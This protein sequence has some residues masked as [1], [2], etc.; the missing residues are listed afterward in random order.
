MSNFLNRILDACDAFWY[1][2]TEDEG[3]RRGELF[4]RFVEGFFPHEYFMLIR[5]TPP[6]DPKDRFSESSLEP[7]FLFEDRGTRK[8][9]YVEAKYRSG[10]DQGKIRACKTLD[11][12]KRYKEFGNCYIMLG[13]GGDPDDPEKLYLI[14]VK[15]LD[16]YTPYPDVIEK[17]WLG[18][19]C[20]CAISFDGSKVAVKKHKTNS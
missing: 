18:H 5:R 16:Y 14:P 6:Y 13:F 15:E 9:F 10:L 3:V 11:Q 1:F 19:D 4:E 2:L 8:R 20:K 7:D 17:Y 12:L